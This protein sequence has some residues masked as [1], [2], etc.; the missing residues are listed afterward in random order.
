MLFRSFVLPD[1]RWGTR[2]GLPNGRVVDA[3]VYDGLWD[4]FYNRHMAI[5]GSEVADEFGFTRE[6]QDQCAYNS[7]M[8]AVKAMNEGK[9][10]A[11]IF[12]VEVK[13]GKKVIV[14]DKD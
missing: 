13:Q 7:Q 14:M 10:D 8:N 1:M 11:E 12:P 3:M 6:E 5:H 9:L 4:A 2:M